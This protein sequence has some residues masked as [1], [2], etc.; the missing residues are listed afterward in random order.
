MAKMWQFVEVA[1]ELAYSPGV[2]VNDIYVR[3]KTFQ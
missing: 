2:S 3:K 1:D